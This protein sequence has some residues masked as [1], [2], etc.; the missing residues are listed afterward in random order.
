[1]EFN[2]LFSFYS[3]R[4][5]YTIEDPI[6]PRNSAFHA[7]FVNGAEGRKQ[8]L[9]IRNWVKWVGHHK[10]NTINQR[11][12]TGGPWAEFL[13]AGDCISPPSFMSKITV[14]LIFVYIVGHKRL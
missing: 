14:Y 5:Q 13:L 2:V 10:V 6:S 12:P 8:S 4:L 11:S 1:M 3:S 7:V 9:S